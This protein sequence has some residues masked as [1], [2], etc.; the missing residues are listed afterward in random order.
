MDNLTFENILL[1]CCGIITH[2]LMMILDR[3]NKSLPL[4]IG[5]F[6]CDVNNYI[7]IAISFISIFVLLIM[8]NDIM[9]TLGI[10]LKDGTGATKLFS[11][12]VGYFN[13]S[14]IRYLVKIFKK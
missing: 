6:L 3:R 14:I 9:D 12:L 5:Y 1:A 11:F 7:R 2:V 10:V 4:T 13:H 8:S